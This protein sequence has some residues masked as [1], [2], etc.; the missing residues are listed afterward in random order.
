MEGS[1]KVKAFIKHSEAVNFLK[2]DYHVTHGFANSIVF[3]SKEE[4]YSDQDL[5][6]NQYLG[7]EAL[8]PIYQTLVKRLLSFGNDIK[9]SPKKDSVSFIRK[10]QFT[11][12]KPA[13]KTRIDLGLKLKGK[14]LTDLLENSGPFGTMCTHRVRISSIE[15][16]DEE[17]MDWM[18]EAYQASI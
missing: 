1:S 16:V 10:R 4:K 12:I 18:L 6:T 5:I 13:T 8:F 11:L 7:K 2:S 14:P 3:L 15:D 17:L 9:V